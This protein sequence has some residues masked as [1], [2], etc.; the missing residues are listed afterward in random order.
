MLIN[1]IFSWLPILLLIPT[2]IFFKDELILQMIAA[3]SGYK[4]RYFAEQEDDRP[5]QQSN[6]QRNLIIQAIPTTV[7]SSTE[8]CNECSICLSDF[9][10]E[11]VVKVLLQSFL[12]Q[13]MHR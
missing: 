5:Q 8:N 3:F 13:N 7:V 9:K 2:Y 6:S 12:S 4:F 11:D 10:A 1:L